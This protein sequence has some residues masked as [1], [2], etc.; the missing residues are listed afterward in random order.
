MF[1]EQT[2]QKSSMKQVAKKIISSRWFLA[3][4]IYFDS[5]GGGEMF[6]RNIG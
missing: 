6:L 2:K 4:F 1:T 5:E 3:W